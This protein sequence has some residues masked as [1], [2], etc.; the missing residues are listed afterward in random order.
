MTLLLLAQVIL[1]KVGHEM[2]RSPTKLDV[3]TWHK[4][5]GVLLLL[6]VLIRLAWRWASPTPS[7]PSSSFI[8]RRAAQISHIG[9]YFLMLLLPLTGWVM[10]SASNIPFK[11]FWLLPWPDITQPSRAVAEMAE[12]LHE[13]LAVFLVA[14]VVLHVAAALWHHFA[15]RDAVLLRML[16]G[17]SREE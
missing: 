13:T 15:K 11:V 1:G 4:S 7:L 9:L 3:L 16:T 6:L 8:Q 5:F 2:A 17:H 10:N 14:L 12:E